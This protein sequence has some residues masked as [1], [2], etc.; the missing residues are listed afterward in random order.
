MPQL[1]NVLYSKFQMSRIIYSIVPSWLGQKMGNSPCQ[2]FAER[3]LSIWLS[4]GRWSLLPCFILLLILLTSGFSIIIRIAPCC[5]LGLVCQR[6]L[7]LEVINLSLHDHDLI[8][9]GCSCSSFPTIHHEG[10][11][12]LCHDDDELFQ[13]DWCSYI[14]SASSF[15]VL[16]WANFLIGLAFNAA[17]K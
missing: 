11:F 13:G 3:G 10:E 8:I 4:S 17:N 16:Y 2:T 6:Q 5:L 15:K 12:L 1:S 9:L 14:I 7:A